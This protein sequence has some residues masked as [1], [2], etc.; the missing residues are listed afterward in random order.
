MSE[1]DN[2]WDSFVRFIFPFLFD[3]DF[4]W[5]FFVDGCEKAPLFTRAIF[6]F[7]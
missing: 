3:F 7:R 5:P 2:T 4:F 1:N 6:S